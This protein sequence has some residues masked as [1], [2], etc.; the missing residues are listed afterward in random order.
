MKKITNRY[1]V[2][3][4]LLA[5]FVMSGMAAF[6][7]QNETVSRALGVN[8]PTVRVE[9]SGDVRRGEKTISLNKSEAVGSG[10]VINWTINSLNDGRSAA[11]N[12]RVVGQIQKGTEFVAASAKADGAAQVSYSIDDGKTFLPEPLIEEK[13]ADGSV[14]LVPAPVSMF[15]QVR[16]E[17]AGALEPNGRFNASYRVRVK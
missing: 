8:R 16:F 11:Q 14:K 17:W 4:L 3:K 2:P 6:A 9:I 10:E 12:Y 15:T 5:L 13:Q 1:F 7:A